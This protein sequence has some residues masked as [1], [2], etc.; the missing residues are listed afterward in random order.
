MK[1][2]SNEIWLSLYEAAKELKSLSPW[3]ICQMD[4]IFIIKE[5]KTNQMAYCF[6]LGSPQEGLSINIA[7]GPEGLSSYFDLSMLGDDA[8]SLFEMKTMFSQQGFTLDFVD[9]TTLTK[10]DYEQIKVLGLSFR[11]KKQW[12]MFRRLYQGSRPWLLQ[13]EEDIIFLTTIYKRL[14]EMI[15]DI[16]IGKIGFTEDDYLFS[17]VESDVW[18]TVYLNSDAIFDEMENV[19][20]YKYTN[21]LMIH[22]LKKLK[23]QNKPLE[24][25]SFLMPN[26][27]W[28]EE[29]NRAIFPV[30]TVFADQES[31]FVFQP[32]M[33]T[34]HKAEEMAIVDHL[35]NLIL[36]QLTYRP[37]EI[38]VDDDALQEIISDFCN[39]IGIECECGPTYAVDEFIDGIFGQAQHEDESE[40]LG[41]PE[42]FL[43]IVQNCEDI[44]GVMLEH[45][46]SQ[47]ISKIEAAYVKDVFICASLYMFQKHYKDPFNWSID[48]FTDMLNNQELAENV[49]VLYPGKNVK[50]I[51]Y[52]GLKHYLTFAKELK[53]LSNSDSLLNL[54]NQ[55]YPQ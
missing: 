11:G 31:E 47:T 41:N 32:V 3:D 27:I 26:E 38:I 53:I 10:E 55:Y 2:V 29:V 17:F 51:I 45:P 19:T 4:E 20:K 36:N 49:Q 39:Q 13:E 37:T 18:K 5:P 44:C 35:A 33:T 46:L 24:A 40:I 48:G 9:R 54:L 30:C 14:I 34:Y 15:S 22:R 52:L 25:V 1:L 6:I 50:P 12:P 8:D 16:K 21:D 42:V 28:D 23:K 43:T 7:L